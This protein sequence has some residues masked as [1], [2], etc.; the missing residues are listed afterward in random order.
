LQ[1]PMIWSGDRSPTLIKGNDVERKH[2]SKIVL[3]AFVG[4]C[5]PKMECCH[6]DDDRSNNALSNLRWDTH[7]ANK[8]DAF[9][10]GAQPARGE[11]ASDVTLTENDV[12]E[13][14]KLRA[15][16]WTLV[17]LGKRYGV[18][19]TTIRC[20]VMGLTWSHVSDGLPEERKMKSEF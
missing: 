3:E 20:A 9:R 19:H 13:A 2:I 12:I 8:M 6:W 11:K 5:P 17:R 10:N 18:V 7:A 14:R 15:K 16:G 4:P 1:K